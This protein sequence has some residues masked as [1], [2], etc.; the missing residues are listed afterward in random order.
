[1]YIAHKIRLYPTKDQEQFLIRSCGVARFSYNWALAKWQEMYEN[2]EKVNEGTLRKDLNAIKRDEFPW[3]MNVS[4][5]VPQSAI[6]A[7]GTAF[8][9]FFRCIKSGGN[10]GY[11]RFKRKHGSR[12]SFTLDCLNFKTEDKHLK[13]AKRKTK[14]KMAERI[15]FPTG[16]PSSVT[17]SRIADRW[18]AAIRFQMEDTII[19][20]ENQ[21]SAVGVD[22]GI[23]SAVTLSCGSKFESPKPLKNHLRKLAKLQRQLSRKQIGSSNRNKA[24]LKVARLHYKVSCVREDFWHKITTAIAKENQTIIIED[25]NVA[26]MMKNRKLSRAL[27]DVSIGMFKPMLEKKA[28]RFGNTIIVI[29]R[30]FPS[31]KTCSSCGFHNAKI[32]LGVTNWECP[33]CGTS[34]DRDINAA[35]NIVA[36]GLG[37]LTPMESS[38][39]GTLVEVGNFRA[40]DDKLLAFVN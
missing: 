20:H 7:L 12:D 11:P 4:K 37:E 28:S 21:G 3:M 8:D 14:I 34:H 25:L 5:C 39:T 10:S 32:V 30:W 38:C 29:D 15:R 33:N 23:T 6:Q 31:S 40:N 22:L 19:T 24:R 16:K 35:K 13:I 9:N 18:F 26:G 1:M 27:V 2:G 17:I 36:E